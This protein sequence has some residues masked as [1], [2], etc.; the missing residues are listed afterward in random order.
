[1]NEPDEVIPQL[2]YLLPLDC[3]FNNNASPN[4]RDDL[5]HSTWTHH[6]KLITTSLLRIINCYVPL[7][8]KLLHKL[9]LKQGCSSRNEIAVA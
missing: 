8:H 6:D 3:D 1:M 9:L 4:L 5:L 2:I 7:A